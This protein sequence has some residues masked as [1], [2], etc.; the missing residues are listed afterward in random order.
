MAVLH[1][2]DSL[3][4]LLS[5]DA[6]FQRGVLLHVLASFAAGEQSTVALQTGGQPLAHTSSGCRAG[7][8]RAYILLYGTCS[9]AETCQVSCTE[10]VLGKL[11]V[12]AGE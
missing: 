8:H 5:A 10:M 9:A 12:H 7:T 1:W 11:S 4:R 2:T 3:L 6:A